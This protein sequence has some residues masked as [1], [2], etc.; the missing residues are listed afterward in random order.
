MQRAHVSKEHC[1]IRVVDNEVVL[2]NLSENCTS[3]NTQVLEAGHQRVLKSG[4]VITIVGR[5]LRYEENKGETTTT[6]QGP[7]RAPTAPQTVAVTNGGAGGV[8][9]R[10][11]VVFASGSRADGQPQRQPQRQLQRKLSRTPRNPDTARKLKLWDAHYSG[12]M[13][14]ETTSDDIFA[15]SPPSG[16]LDTSQR[17]LAESD[18]PFAASNT[19]EEG[20][21]ER[22]AQSVGRGSEVRR[23]PEVAA[24]VK[25]IMGQINQMA[26]H[27]NSPSRLTTPLQSGRKRPRSSTDAIG[28]ERKRSRSL[29]RE[30]QPASASQR[31]LYPPLIP[32]KSSVGAAY[33]SEDETSRVTVGV[34]PQ[35][36]YNRSPTL[37]RQRQ[38]EGGSQSVVV[39]RSKPIQR[40]GSTT[41]AKTPELHR[42]TARFFSSLPR[43]INGSSSVVG[44]RAASNGSPTP[45]ARMSS[46]LKRT[47]S[48]NSNCESVIRPPIMP[49]RPIAADDESEEVPTEPEPESESDAEPIA[50]V[51]PENRAAGRPLLLA[52]ESMARKSVRFGPAL[53]PE[54]FDE[55][56]P[57]STPLRRGTPMQLPARA[58]S[59]L[60]R[61]SPTRPQP[62]SPSLL[63][64]LLTPRPT[65]RQAMHQYIASLSAL[66]ESPLAVDQPPRAAA[67]VEPVEE[68]SVG[69]PKETLPVV[70]I[71]PAAP[72]EPLVDIEPVTT[73]EPV[74]DIESATVLG[75]S[76]ADRRQ[77]R[78]RS[79]RLATNH[80]QRR[81]TLDS[82]LRVPLQKDSPS[83]S[84]PSLL[85]VKRTTQSHPYLDSPT[86]RPPPTMSISAQRR[87]RRRTAPIIG[88]SDF[89]A[90]MAQMAAALGED[91]PTLFAKKMPPAAVEKVVDDPVVIAPEDDATAVE[92]PE[93]APLGLADA[94]Q[95]EQQAEDDSEANTVVEEASVSPASNVVLLEQ[96]ERQARIQGTSPESSFV[97][98]DSLS[99][100]VSTKL[101]GLSVTTPPPT[102]IAL[103]SSASRKH[104][105]QTIADFAPISE[106]EELS[107]VDEILAHRQR[108]KRIQDR[109][110][111]RQTVADL[112]KR[113]SSWRGWMPTA[114][115]LVDSPP[116]SPEAHHV[117]DWSRSTDNASFLVSP[118]PPPPALNTLMYPPTAWN[119]E[120]EGESPTKRRRRMRGITEIVGS[121][122]GIN[123]KPASIELANDPK[124]GTREVAP[125]TETKD[126]AYPPRPVPID[127]DWEKIDMDNGDFDNGEERLANEEITTAEEPVAEASQQ[128]ELYAVSGPASDV[129]SASL[130]SA[131]LPAE[132]EHEQAPA[133][134]EEPVVSTVLSPPTTRGRASRGQRQTSESASPP[135]PPSTTAATRRTTIRP[136]PPPP[137]T[138]RRAPATPTTVPTTM[139]RK[140]RAEDPAPTTPAP[141]KRG[142]GRPPTNGI[143]KTPEPSVM[144][145]PA[146][147]ASKKKSHAS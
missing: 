37:Q 104:R 98:G 42:T 66:A 116:S 92:E 69:V 136:P 121:V 29:E 15:E 101:A 84:S 94:M 36:T 28:G 112:N 1:V 127:A 76:P 48:S 124:H 141:L 146:T 59:I 91:V 115:P 60:R 53:S 90:S 56:A 86:K 50:V 61:T 34:S 22:M 21:F 83:S 44:R 33:G 49:L 19:H 55:S 54:V 57:P 71:E 119:T 78:R 74:V 27:N 96:A 87:E 26:G 10:Q 13:N 2:K 126:F 114:N 109:K 122:L 7:S 81:V 32:Q 38:G 106:V 118:P 88:S 102:P 143:R 20:A 135:P 95:Q 8:G 129:D 9:G 30:Q 31:Q 17:L 110:R 108:L 131:H 93:V 23:D 82:P 43:P 117:A 39:Q 128:V 133:A 140:R 67:A 107:S 64:S 63:R 41:I 35:S 52:Q 80:Q 25:R 125:V 72:I 97:V 70:G 4:D 3:V 105:R 120:E 75:A 11:P 138:R 144:S 24:E 113:R 111:R 103:S 145:P 142:R 85:I 132:Q 65:R 134:V 6:P 12:N 5:S 46:P 139:T 89:S 45:S 100:G 51:T 130:F 58:S 99:L 18:D 73:Q 137:S 40:A 14:A 79:V 62:V 77:R 16:L 68:A 147:R 47:L 123:T